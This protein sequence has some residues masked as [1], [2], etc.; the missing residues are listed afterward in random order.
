MISDDQDNSRELFHFI[1]VDSSSYKANSISYRFVPYPIEL[2]L[3][4]F[5][6][7]RRYAVPKD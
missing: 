3:F 5:W 7:I 4:W 1:E 6:I 2:D